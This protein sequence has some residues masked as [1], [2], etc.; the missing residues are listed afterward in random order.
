MRRH[1][2]V[3]WEPFKVGSSEIKI[4]AQVKPVNEVIIVIVSRVLLSA[5]LRAEKCT[6]NVLF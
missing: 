6:L 2:S 3:V 1:L 4:L 5:K